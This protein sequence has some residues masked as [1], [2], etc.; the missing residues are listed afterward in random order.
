[1]L[2]FANL[3]AERDYPDPPRVHWLVLSGVFGICNLV[4]AHYA[5]MRFQELLQSLVIDTRAFYLCVWIRKLDPDSLSPFWCDAYVI[6]ELAFAA[7][8]I[9][10]NPSAQVQWISSGLGFASTVLGITT[11]FLI[12]RDLL[13][14]YNEKEDFTLILSPVMTLFFSFAYFQYH[15]YDIAEQKLKERRTVAI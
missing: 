11:I 15:L 3:S 14:H 8:D 12:R 6:V 1:L 9:W 7:L 2:G 4:I 13:K 10:Q 5:P